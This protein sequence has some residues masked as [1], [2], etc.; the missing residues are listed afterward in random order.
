MFSFSNW[1]LIVAGGSLLFSLFELIL[2]PGRMNKFIK[3]TLNIF[4]MYI[5]IYPIITFIKD[6]V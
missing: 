2:P 1:M 6:V 4:Y 5:I 3:N